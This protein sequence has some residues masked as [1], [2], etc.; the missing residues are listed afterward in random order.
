V[1]LAVHEHHFRDVREEILHKYIRIARTQQYKQENQ[2]TLTHILL[3]S[4]R[5]NNNFMLN[6]RNFAGQA[7]REK[8]Q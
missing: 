6:F 2:N 7:D 4:S 3:C 1:R 8:K 5:K